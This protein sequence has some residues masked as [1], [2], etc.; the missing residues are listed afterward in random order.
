M[1]KQQEEWDRKVAE[2]K[3]LMTVAQKEKQV[4]NGPYLSNINAD[5][6]M[7]G[8][9]KRELVAGSNLVGKETPNSKPAIPVKGAGLANEH[10][11]IEYNEQEDKVTVF[12]NEDFKNHS[13]K[14]NGELVMTPTVLNPGDRILFGSHIYYIYIHPN[15]NRDATFDYEDAVKEANKDSMSTRIEDDKAL[16]ELDEMKKKMQEEAD[17]TQKEI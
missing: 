1:R 10:C 9:I 13:T 2:T 7:S 4:L 15:V 8:M 6:T 14:I 16:K 11:T 12:P 17:R 5:S 3:K